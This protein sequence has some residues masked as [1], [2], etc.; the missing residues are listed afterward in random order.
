[1][2]TTP[3]QVEALLSCKQPAPAPALQNEGLISGQGELPYSD[4]H[5]G[6]GTYETSG[7]PYIATYN[8]MQLIGKP[9]NLSQVAND[10]LSCYGTVG[11]GS[12]GV[13]P[14]S[15]MKYLRSHDVPYTGSF[16]PEKLTVNVSEG[17]VFI[18]TI[19]NT[20]GD[21]TAGWH[22]MTAIYAL[23]QYRVYNRTNSRTDYKS[24]DSLNEACEDGVWLYGLLIN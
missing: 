7:C 16:S 18:F 20:K 6:L 13:R 9:Q 5:V 10:Y 2:Y 14:S 8:A 11:Y 12:L 17:D 21:L 4:Y 23:G 22:T 19:W 15:I 24:Y 1:M 3:E